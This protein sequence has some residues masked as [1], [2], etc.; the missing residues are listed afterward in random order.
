MNPSHDNTGIKRL[1]D[2]SKRPGK[3]LRRN[4][5]WRNDSEKVMSFTHVATKF[6]LQTENTL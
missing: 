2:E 6:C 1:G 3:C 5:Q 4:L